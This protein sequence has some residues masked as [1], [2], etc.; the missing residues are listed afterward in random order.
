MRYYMEHRNGYGAMAA[1]PLEIFVSF[2]PV[3]QHSNRRKGA[4][5]T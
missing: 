1:E 5:G 4:A 2:L 3:L